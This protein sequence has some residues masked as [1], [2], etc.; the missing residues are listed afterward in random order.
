MST[1][2]EVPQTYNLDTTDA[3]QALDDAGFRQVAGDAF[4]RFRYADG[5][6]FARSIAFQVVM[7]VIPGVIFFVALA[8]RLGDG[9]LRRVISSLIESL[10]PGPAGDM[11]REAFAQGSTAGSTGNVVAIVAGAVAMLIGA[12][13]AMSQVQ[14][15]ASRIY[16]VDTDRTTLLRYGLATLLALTTG[17][18]LSAAFVALTLGGSVQG[19]FGDEPNQFWAMARWP[20]G[21]L[22]LGAGLTALFKVAPN[23]KQPGFAWLSSGAAL[24]L[25]GWF[26]VS[27]LLS[28]YLNASGTFGDTYGPLAGFVGLM[29]WAQ[30]SA[31]AILYG[32]SFAA[33]L[34]AHRAGVAEPREDEAEETKA[35]GSDRIDVPLDRLVAT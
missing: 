1:A 24:A 22:A 8:V 13:A 30:F 14:R 5:F 15:G 23:R 25:L 19:A 26:A 6:S 34:E 35:A 17:V 12:V 18:L 28:L 20:L 2:T 10:A 21:L 16:G 27:A 9:A 11:F 31:I 7:T 29:L 32:L 4:I 33:Q 3:R